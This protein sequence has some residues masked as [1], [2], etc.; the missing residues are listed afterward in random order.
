MD[1]QRFT[2]DS[3]RAVLVLIDI[4]DKLLG[5]MPRDIQESVV[6]SAGNLVKGAKE[7]NIPILATEQYPQGLG[8]TIKAIRDLAPEIK[9]FP[10]LTFSCYR[11]HEFRKALELAEPR[12]VILCGME[13][14]LCVLPTALELLEDDYN[15][16]VAA[17]AVCSRTKLNWKLSLEVMRQAGA[18][19]GTSEMFLYQMVEEAGTE[20]FKNIAR[21]LK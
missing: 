2:P 19:I 14:H 9:P 10:K 3:S 7:L 16:F 15:V 18:T 6:K 20:R 5:T 1:I 17:D 4:Q 12:D 21:I 8:Q 13:T 11:N